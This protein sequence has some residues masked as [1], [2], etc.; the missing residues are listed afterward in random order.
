[1]LTGPGRSKCRRP[2]W[3]ERGATAIEYAVFAA[4]LGIGL[5]TAV[6]GLGR[7][8]LDIWTFVL[9]GVSKVL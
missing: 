8:V 6:N 4:I 5:I 1:M 3:N 9:A 2:S 7:G